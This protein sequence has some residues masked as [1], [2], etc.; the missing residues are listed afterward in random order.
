MSDATANAPES[1]I[2]SEDALRTR[3]ATPSELVQKKRVARLDKHCRDFIALSPFVMLGTADAEGHVD[4][5]P[6]G[7]PPG[8]VKVLDDTT[9]LMPDRPG[10][11]LIDSLSNIVANPQ[12]GLLF[13][14]PGFDDTLRVNGAATLTDDPALLA[15][16]AIDGRPP[17][18]AIR[19]AVRE[20]F[21]HCARSFRRARLWE[22]AAQVPRKTLPTLATMVMGMTAMP[23]DSE[24]DRRVEDAMQKLY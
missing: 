19:V 10:N 15:M 1:C 13:L 2:D 20:A 11:N 4:V 17:K 24:I 5:S 14:I 7:D 22:P 12:V 6:R 21:L 3:Y 8:F 18:L 16:L 9:L 23:Y